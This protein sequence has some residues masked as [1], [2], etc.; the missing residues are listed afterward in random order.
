MKKLMYMVLCIA[1]V[2][3]T[4]L[5]LSGCSQVED[6]P[7]SAQTDS[8]A[9]S[10]TPSH[11]T[12]DPSE[13]I[14]VPIVEI[15]EPQP[16]E[17]IIHYGK[18]QFRMDEVTPLTPR[19]LSDSPGL[20][21]S[22]DYVIES[23]DC[24]SGIICSDLVEYEISDGGSA[25]LYISGSV[26]IPELSKAEVGIVNHETSETWYMIRSV[27]VFNDCTCTFTEL[28]AGTY[29]VYFRNL[30]GKAPSQLYIRYH[31]T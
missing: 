22:E 16:E 24:E 25:T 5:T 3:S 7:N 27:G 30:E 29:S 17:Y 12:I 21:D 23:N 4:V 10:E 1:L 15:P 13:I 2:L 6:T 19:K 31:L 8:P 9:D 20:E 11:G 14:R 26:W 28:T 18:D